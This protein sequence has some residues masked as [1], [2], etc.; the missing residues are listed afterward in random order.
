VTRTTQ[1]VSGRNS[2]GD[3]YRIEVGAYVS[4]QLEERIG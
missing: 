2:A 4:Y 3:E 1:V